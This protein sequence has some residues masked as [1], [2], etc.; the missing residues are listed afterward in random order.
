[1]DLGHVRL[2]IIAGEYPTRY[3]ANVM[4]QR[5]Q[6]PLLASG[7]PHV[8]LISAVLVLASKLRGASEPA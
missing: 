1:L 6:A 5:Q 7:A 4:Y 3:R 8:V 2:S